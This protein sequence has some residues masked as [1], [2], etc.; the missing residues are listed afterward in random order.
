MGTIT[1]AV[2]LAS[3]TLLFLIGWSLRRRFTG[4]HSETETSRSVSPYRPADHSRTSG[5]FQASPEVS[6]GMVACPDCGTENDSAYT[7]CRRCVADL[8]AGPNG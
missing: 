5:A 2:L 1:L 8:T 7:F 3:C 6:A 4:M